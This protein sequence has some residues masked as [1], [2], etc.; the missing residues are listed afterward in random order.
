[1]PSSYDERSRGDPSAC[2]RAAVT[3]AS[4]RCMPGLTGLTS[5]ETAL[6]KARVP[7]AHVT[8][9]ATPGENPPGSLLH[10]VTGDPSASSAQARTPAGSASNAG[11]VMQ[12][13]CQARATG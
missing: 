7:S 3:A 2:G 11:L 9:A 13:R 5:A 10:A 1:M 4:V 6:T 8:R 12:T